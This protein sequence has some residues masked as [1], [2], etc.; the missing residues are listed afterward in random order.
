[1]PTLA[2]RA[3]IGIVLL[4]GLFAS[5]WRYGTTQERKNCDL[6]RAQ[7]VSRAIEQERFIA[8]QDA[9][10]SAGFETTRTRI[11]TI[12]RNIEKEVIREIPADCTQCRIAPT[13]L[14]MLNDAISGRAF[15][16]TPPGKPDQPLRVPE[17]APGRN[18]P[19]SGIEI[20]GIERK[21]L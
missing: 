1:M 10:V 15:K 18:V 11:Q 21:T 14:G 20:G 4:L 19:R 2:I 9:E 5:G 7:A 13:G 8:K 16:T 12:Y 3:T 17:S 6:A